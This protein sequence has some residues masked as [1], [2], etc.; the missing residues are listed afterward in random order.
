MTCGL[1]SVDAGP[2][3]FA[4]PWLR[5]NRPNTDCSALPSNH[6]VAGKVPSNATASNDTVEQDVKRGKQSPT[7]MSETAHLSFI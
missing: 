5:T 1:T 4:P 2:L 7:S 3:L 6:A